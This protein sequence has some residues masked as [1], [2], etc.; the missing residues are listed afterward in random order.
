MDRNNFYPKPIYI[1]QLKPEVVNLVDVGEDLQVVIIK[2]AEEIFVIVDICPHMGGYLS[3]GRYCAK[4]RTFQCPWHGYIFDLDTGLFRK[5]PNEI[6]WE[7]LRYSTEHFKPK[8]TPKYKLNQLEYE[9]DQDKI[10]VRRQS[11]I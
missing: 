1:T 8:T 6:I 5:N 2:Q 10:Y 7:K 9:I 4:S 3:Q 11:K